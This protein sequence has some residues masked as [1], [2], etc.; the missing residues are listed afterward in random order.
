VR[1]RVKLAETLVGMWTPHL[2]ALPDDCIT[3]AAYRRCIIQP[4]YISPV[5]GYPPQPSPAEKRTKMRQPRFFDYS[6][7][8]VEYERIQT[9]PRFEFFSQKKH[10][11]FWAE[12]QEHT[13]VRQ[14]L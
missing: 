5:T 12:D 4:G 10:R 2:Q 1:K 8:E 3:R 9:I 14:C 6:T 7:A 11:H 13:P